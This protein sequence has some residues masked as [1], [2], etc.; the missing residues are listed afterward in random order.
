MVERRD[1]GLGLRGAELAKSGLPADTERHRTKARPANWDTREAIPA[2]RVY[3]GDICLRCPCGRPAPDSS[4][5]DRCGLGGGP[6]CRRTTRRST[7]NL[8]GRC[9]LARL[10]KWRGAGTGNSSKEKPGQKSWLRKSWSGGLDSNQ[11]PLDPQSSALPNCATT[12]YVAALTRSRR[13]D[14]IS[15]KPAQGLF[16]GNCHLALATRDHDVR[17]SSFL[18]SRTRRRAKTASVTGV[19]KMPMKMRRALGQSEPRSLQ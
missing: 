7:P 16:W 6:A 18:S 10:H 14:T 5:A 11:R 12:R 1:H 15:P 4:D 8:N 2:L 17:S 13:E 19:M 3:R 9:T